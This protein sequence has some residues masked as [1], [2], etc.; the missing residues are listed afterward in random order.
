[1]RRREKLLRDTVHD[2]IEFD[3]DQ[4]DDR[5]LWQLMD[6]REFQRL[7]AIRQMGMAHFAYHGCEHSRFPHSVGVMHLTR[8]MLGRLVH[9]WNV[10]EDTLLAVKCAG[11]L[12][13]LGHGPF[14]HVIEHWFD[15]HH[16]A[17]T[18]RIILDEG[19]EIHA[20]L[21]TVHK[22]FPRKVADVLRGHVKPAWLKYI[23]SSQLDADRFDYLIRDS[24]MTGVKYGV[25]DLER[26]IMMLRV[27]DDGER[28]FVPAKG[29]LPVEKYLQSRYHMYRQVYFHKAVASGE[30]VLIALLER[31]SELAREGGCPGLD[32]GSP[33]G[34]VLAGA[35]KS[36]T[37]DDYVSLDDSTVWGA[38]HAWERGPDKILKDLSHRLLTRKLY[39][40]LE[41]P[42]PDVEDLEF[43]MRLEAARKALTDAGHDPRYYLR[44]SHSTNLPY[45]PYNPRS[46]RPDETIWI[47]VPDVPGTYTDVTH[48][49]PT[50]KA[51]TESPYSVWRAFFP[52]DVRADMIRVM[53]G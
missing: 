29:L 15:D 28:V 22:G 20:A 38:I 24:L 3:L 8:R 41:I 9:G 17:W 25:F 34:R 4:R 37:V 46:V 5:L 51:F 39:K 49:S 12:H 18:R 36:V 42:D 40:S 52:E 33:L 31:A 43:G 26:L 27:S 45:K 16:E 30:A 10:D 53:L 47:E 35:G 19:T 6:T 11:L 1:M 14:S 2:L 50:I 32:S 7:R 23:V 48:V 21:A 13:D 44:L